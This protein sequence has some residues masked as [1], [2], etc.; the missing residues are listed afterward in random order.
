MR[1]IKFKVWDIFKKIF[2]P[3]DVWAIINCNNKTS[4]FWIMI[5]DWE[6]Y[7]VW[8][9]FYNN[10]QILLQFTWLL[11]KNWVEIY[12]WDI[13]NVTL[14]RSITYEVIFCTEEW[15]L[16]I[17]WYFWL[18]H[19]HMVIGFDSMVMNRWEVIWNIYDNPELVQE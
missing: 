18:K 1:E 8:E 17:S 15:D 13:I 6:S 4:A 11:D 3:E 7:Q 2:I 12:E 14:W 19:K 10:M 16:W 5:K 9:V